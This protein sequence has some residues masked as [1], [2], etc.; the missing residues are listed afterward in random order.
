MFNEK[1]IILQTKRLSVSI[2][3]INSLDNWYKLQ[4]DKNVMKYIGDGKARNKEEIRK[5]LK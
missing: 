5:K 2:S 4:S 3:T 1:N